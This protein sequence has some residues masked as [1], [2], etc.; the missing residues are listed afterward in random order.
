MSMTDTKSAQARV[1][2]GINQMVGQ[3]QRY[4][5]GAVTR[6]EGSLSMVQG[7][8]G[9]SSLDHNNPHYLNLTM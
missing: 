9:V 2:H 4:C 6:F 3:I 1:G 8:G 7:V 5:M